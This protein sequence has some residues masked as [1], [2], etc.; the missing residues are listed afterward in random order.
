MR[1]L[2]SLLIVVACLSTT[3]PLLAV[4]FRVESKVYS[5]KDEKHQELISESETLSQRGVVYDFLSNPSTIA[6]YDPHGRFILLDAQR[7]VRTEL[8]KDE[9]KKFCEGLQAEAAKSS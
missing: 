3:R 9:V 7:R 8:S 5:V 1:V 6:V 4:D 2:W